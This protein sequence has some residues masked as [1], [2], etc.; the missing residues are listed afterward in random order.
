MLVCIYELYKIKGFAYV[1]ELVVYMGM[2]SMTVQRLLS[3]MERMHLLSKLNCKQRIEGVKPAVSGWT[4]TQTAK[5]LI[6]DIR[7]SWFRLTSDL[8]A[9]DNVAIRRV[10]V[11]S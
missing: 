11:E 1:R 10:R 5:D 8:K 2:D 7:G 6:N 3:E 4:V 9:G